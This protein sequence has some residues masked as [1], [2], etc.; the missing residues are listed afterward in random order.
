MTITRRRELLF[1]ITDT[2]QVTL[3]ALTSVHN[4]RN[5]TKYC[6]IFLVAISKDLEVSVAFLTVLVMVLD[7]VR[8]TH[9]EDLVA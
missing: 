3:A 6:Q 7:M 9:L 4:S 1:T 2:A 5:L 8:T